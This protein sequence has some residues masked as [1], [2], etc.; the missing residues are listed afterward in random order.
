MN[1]RMEQNADQSDRHDVGN[2]A[3]DLDRIDRGQHGGRKPGK[4]AGHI[5][6]A[7]ILR[8]VVVGHVA[9]HT[10]AVH[11]LAVHSR[12]VH[13][14]RV[15]RRGRVHRDPGGRRTRAEDDRH[16]TVIAVNHVPGGHQQ[17]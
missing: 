6:L 7:M 16:V 8:P 5:D 17:L 3:S 10:L 12:A 14:G 9:V 13:V 15:H 1:R 4:G 2:Q 11:S